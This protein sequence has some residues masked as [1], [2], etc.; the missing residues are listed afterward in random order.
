MIFNIKFA[1]AL[2]VALQCS[3]TFVFA[4]PTPQ[5]G[6]K[7]SATSASKAPATSASKAPAA[8][9]TTQQSS[10]T[11]INSGSCGADAQEK[12]LK[13][14]ETSCEAIAAEVGSDVATLLKLNA[15]KGVTQKHCDDLKSKKL[16]SGE[17]AGIKICVPKK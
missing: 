2:L 8:A 7:P 13:G 6:T 9:P 5:K 1:A 16:K 17:V 3:A 15:A 12:T 11:A 10:K 14:G 4:A